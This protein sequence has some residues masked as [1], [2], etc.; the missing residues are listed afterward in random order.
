MENI[1]LKGYVVIKDKKT[2]KVLREGHNM[3]L[4]AGRNYL[5]SL[6]LNK[7]NGIVTT[8]SVQSL[9]DDY[10]NMLNYSLS[11]VYYYYDGEEGNTY[12]YRLKDD[13]KEKK[14]SLVKL[15]TQ[16][17]NVIFSPCPD[18]N[19]KFRLEISFDIS[20]NEITFSKYD[21]VVLLLTNDSKTADQKLTDYKLFSRF[22]FDTLIIDKE[23]DVSMVYYIYF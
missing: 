2:G 22:C 16:N 7:N 1:G 12:K 18:D 4:E 20:T 15:T 14:E 13:I 23:S 10:S 3:I 19:S 17:Q 21:S 6:F 5:L 9:L 11:H 8:E